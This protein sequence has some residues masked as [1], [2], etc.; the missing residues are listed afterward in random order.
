MGLNKEQLVLK[1]EEAL[2]GL[3][4][5]PDNLKAEKRQKNLML[6]AL[7][8]FVASK[9]EIFVVREWAKT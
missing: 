4:W 2:S 7:L 6:H 8:G 5:L 9:E 3:R 1:A